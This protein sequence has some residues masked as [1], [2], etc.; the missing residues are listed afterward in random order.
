MHSF[1]LPIQYCWL[2]FSLAFALTACNTNTPSTIKKQVKTS[3]TPSEL[4]AL[5]VHIIA[6]DYYELKIGVKGDELTGV[7]YDP[8]A[9]K[10]NNCLFFFE[11]TIGT[12]NPVLVKCYNPT[13]TEAPINGQFKLLGDAMIL[14]LDQLPKTTCTPEFTDK[15]GRSVVLD[16]QAEWSAIRM[17]QFAAKMYAKPNLEEA[18]SSVEL[19]KGTV[20]AIKE[21]FKD[22]ILVDVLTGDERQ[23]GWIAM[24]SLYPLIE[25]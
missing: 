1:H 11:G 21:K 6:G 13:T 20:V 24:Q 25:L 4:D 8:T 5:N 23:Q 22:W 9:S 15:V 10:D 18:M 7:Y 3:W 12:S 16:T 2:A 17:L 19:S 14:Q